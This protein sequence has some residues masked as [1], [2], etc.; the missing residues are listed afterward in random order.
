MK[1]P[2][3]VFCTLGCLLLSAAHAGTNTPDKSTVPSLPPLEK[4]SDWWYN[5][6]TYAWLS[7]VDGDITFKGLTVP[8]DLGMEDV[9]GHLDFT[10][11]VYL[12]A[13]RGRWSAGLDAI[14][15]R[16][17]D[18]TTFAQGP[19]SGSADLE[20][21][22]AFVT[23]RVNFRAVDTPKVKLD[24]FAGVR[25]TY[26][27]LNVDVDANIGARSVNQSVDFFDPVIGARTFVFLSDK[28]FIQAGGDIG[29]FGVGSDLTWQ[30]VGGIGYRLNSNWSIL[31][32]YRAMGVDYEK[33]GS[34]I[35]TLFKG[36]T[37]GVSVRF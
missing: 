21:N 11:M 30:A 9:L 16:L 19:V 24:L 4:K 12:E 13:G 36:P 28:W 22:Q 7:G 8:V 29:G 34:K 18:H 23:A 27:D 6:T 2:V 20:E 3:P 33:D 32:G 10:Y 15:A 14:Y 17:S 35:D 31:A 25:W 26:F 1:L 37:L 5:A